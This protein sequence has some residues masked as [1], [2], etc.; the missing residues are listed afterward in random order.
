MSLFAGVGGIDLGLEAAGRSLGIPVEI[1]A[2][3][4][5]NRHSQAVLR[6]HWPGIR[7]W[8]DITELPA[9]HVP[10]CDLIAFGSPCQ[11]LSTIGKRG[12]LADSSSSG[13]FYEVVRIMKE[14]RREGRQ[15][16]WALWENVVGSLSSTE[17]DDFA[18]VLDLL[19]ECGAVDIQW[20]VLD[21]SYFGV[22]H[23]RRRVF[24]LACFDSGVG[25]VPSVLHDGVPGEGHP[26]PGQAQRPRTARRARPGVQGNPPGVDRPTTPMMLKETYDAKILVGPMSWTLTTAGGKWGQGRAAAWIPDENGGTIRTLTETEYERLM[27]WPDGHTAEGV[28]PGNGTWQTLP[29][30]STERYRMSCAAPDLGQ[31]RTG[32]TSQQVLRGRG[33]PVTATKPAVNPYKSLERGDA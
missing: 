15:P 28:Y 5:I 31:R 9:R 19:A 11:A 1:V 22:P 16:R 27:G 4:E 21:A 12:G 7:L 17:G 3:A 29:V 25:R 6:R 2:Q 13:L 10:D 24:V 33:C 26:G 23:R 8:F 30:P 20:R 32:S 18:T 14:L